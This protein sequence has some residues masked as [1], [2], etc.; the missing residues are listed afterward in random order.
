MNKVIVLKGSLAKGDHPINGGGNEL[1][2]GKFV[3]S[4]KILNLINDLKEQEKYWKN[5]KIIGNAL[6]N[7]EYNCIASKSNRIKILLFGKYEKNASDF[8]R[9]AKF[10]GDNDLNRRHLITY[11]IE[12][13][14]IPESIKLLENCLEVINTF[15]KGKILSSDMKKIKLENMNILPDFKKYGLTMTSFKM[16]IKD[17]YYVNKITHPQYIIS[18]ENLESH[19]VTLYDVNTPLD[20]LLN[21]IGIKIKEGNKLEK[22]TFVMNNEE[23]NKLITSAPYLVSM[24]ASNIADIPSVNLNNQNNYNT[25]E[26][27]NKI[28]NFPK[29]TNEPIIGV[30]DTGFNSNAYFKEWI[31]YDE[32]Y[33]AHE[34]RDLVDNYHGTCV[35]SIIVDGPSLNPW[36]QDNCGRFRVKHFCVIT[37]EKDTVMNIYMRIKEIVSDNRDIKVW[38]LSLGSK[39]EI[40]DN[41]ISQIAALLDELQYEYDIIFI[42]AGTNNKEYENKKNLKIG[43]PADSINSIVVNSVTKNNKIADYSRHGNV[44]SFFNKPDVCYYGGDK[45]VGIVLCSGNEIVTDYGTSFA[46]PWI[47]RKIAFMIYKL[48]LSREIAKALLIDST[49]KWEPIKNNNLNYYGYGIVPIKIEDIINT[50]N[51]EIKFCIESESYSYDTYTYNIPV[52]KIQK[53]NRKNKSIK[54]YYP[55]IAKVTMCY[56]PKCSRNQG[57]DY[58]NTELLIK[59]GRVYTDKGK[60]IRIRA[61]DNNNQ[62]EEDDRTTEKNAR[63]EYRK[64]DNVKHICEKYDNRT[65]ER[66]TFDKFN[67]GISVKSIDRLGKKDGNGLKFGAVLTLKEINGKNR[68]EEFMKLCNAIGWHVS[69]IDIDNEI[70]IFNQEEEEIKFE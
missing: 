40:N 13:S 51:D 49:A 28:S 37:S 62:Y 26:I 66:E 63:N 34:I 22:N 21:R 60:S 5:K 48:H 12:K 57:V 68:I 20:E 35:D 30:L 25:N 53:E 4:D 70:R 23:I 16:L 14:N 54:E 61:L 59:F 1:P 69:K 9:G 11:Y 24:S 36:L 56:F 8:I 39:T 33:I 15:Y 44:L 64:W 38:N 18:N 19:I 2:K 55:F 17:C 65:R 7:V 29:P 58:T 42:V 32:N 50:K 47:A 46:S 10:I 41:F 6:L 52:P 45:R 27:L 31:N 67:W 3:D 43:S